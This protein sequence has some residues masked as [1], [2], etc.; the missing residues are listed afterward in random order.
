MDIYIFSD[1]SG[2][3]DKVHNEWYVFGGI[4]FLSR[5]EKDEAGRRYLAA[6]E[7]IRKSGQ[8]QKQELKASKIKNKDKRKLYRRMEN[9][10]RFGVVIEQKR[11]LDS[12]MA[13]K[14][15][16]QRYLDYAYKIGVKRLLLALIHAG[17]IHPEE[18]R[19]VNFSIDEHTTA[20]DGVYELRESLEEEFKHGIH[21]QDFTRFHPPIFPKM[22]SVNL[23]YCNSATD[24]LVRAADI[25]ANRIYHDVLEGVEQKP[26]HGEENRILITRLPETNL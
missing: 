5:E 1:E 3:F 9:A 4:V 15:S 25:V 21:N 23:R 24:T 22:H 12:I 8:Y 19:N 10:Y 11:V 6:E 20:T 2:V 14:K 18:V 17:K 26:F 13:A 7:N 16:K